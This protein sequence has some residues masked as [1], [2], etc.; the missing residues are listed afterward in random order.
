MHSDWVMNA[1]LTQIMNMNSIL[2]ENIQLMNCIYIQSVAKC[3]S[4]HKQEAWLQF[5]LCIY[6]EIKTT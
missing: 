3:I 5:V 6:P 1:M 4:R 2:Y